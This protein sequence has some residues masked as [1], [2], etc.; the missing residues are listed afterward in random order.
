MSGNHAGGFPGFGDFGIPGATISV[1]VVSVRQ[2]RRFL[3]L[4]EW[5]VLPTVI[6]S[7]YLQKWR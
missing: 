4:A 2:M 6:E 7:H 5:Q 1:R 3:A